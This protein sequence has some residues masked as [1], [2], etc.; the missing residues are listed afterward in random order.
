MTTAI[1]SCP[2]RSSPTLYIPSGKLE[3]IDNYLSELTHEY[4]DWKLKAGLLD[5]FGADVSESWIAQRKQELHLLVRPRLYVTCFSKVDKRAS[6]TPPWI[7]TILE[8]Y[9]SKRPCWT[10]RRVQHEDTI[11][12]RLDDECRQLFYRIPVEDLVEY[13]SGASSEPIDHFLFFH[14]VVAVRLSR[15]IK[16]NVDELAKYMRVMEVCDCPLDSATLLIPF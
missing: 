2:P 12:V 7:T 11:E 6:Q 14:H 16:D 13:G 4:P 5:I 1:S 10:P 8:P 15:Y 3:H 9:S